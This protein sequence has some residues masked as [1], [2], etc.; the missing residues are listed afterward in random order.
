MHKR[1]ELVLI[2]LALSAFLTAIRAD[3]D[4]ASASSHGKQAKKAEVKK[5]D[6]SAHVKWVAQCLRDI[7]KI[8]PGMTKGELLKVF[9]E[10]GGLSSPRTQTFVHREC[11]LMQVDVTF[12]PHVG[13]NPG[14]TKIATIS[15]P[16]LDWPIDD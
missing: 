1:T 10:G 15:K 14:T 13:D 8:K 7:Q 16:Y 3:A 6:A 4:P 2:A 9:D 11:P 5:D 12:E